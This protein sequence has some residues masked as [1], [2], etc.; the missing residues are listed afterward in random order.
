MTGVVLLAR[1]ARPPRAGR[2]GQ[3]CEQYGGVNPASRSS[4]EAAPDIASS[5]PKLRITAATVRAI[6]FNF[7]K[8]LLR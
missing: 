8:G 3:G 2:V 6:V 7:I 4:A 5:A 1:E